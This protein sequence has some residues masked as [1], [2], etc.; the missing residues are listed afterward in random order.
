MNLYDLTYLEII[1]ALRKID[2]VHEIIIENEA[3]ITEADLIFCRFKG[4]RFNLKYDLNYGPD[5]DAVG[6]INKSDLE[7][8]EQ[9]IIQQHRSSNKKDIK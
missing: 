8:I 4:E 7:T 5:L 6:N 2:P 9:L 1:D 3:F